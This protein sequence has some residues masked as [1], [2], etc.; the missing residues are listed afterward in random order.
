MYDMW[1][2][3]TS[4]ELYPHGVKGQKWGVRRYQNSDGSLTSAGKR[5][6][7]D[8]YSQQQRTR[9]RRVYG[10]RAVR[11]INRRMLEGENVSSARAAEATRIN[12]AR[13]AATV[14]GIAGSYAGAIGGAVGG[15]VAGRAIGPRIANMVLARTGDR[16]VSQL[17][18]A[19]VYG[20]F[21][22]GGSIAGSV[23]GRVGS[24]SAAMAIGGYDPAHYRR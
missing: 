6:Y 10:N 15:L 18:G 8:N 5:R 21:M 12:R 20:A 22:G 23:L 3:G 2:T 1:Y 13:S 14:S 24:Q 19:G 4:D 11:R 17:V 7:A 16:E 9:D